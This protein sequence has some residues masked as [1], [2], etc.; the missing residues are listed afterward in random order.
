MAHRWLQGAIKDKSHPV[1][2]AAKENGISALQESRKESHSS[3]QSV[4]SRG[5]LG[6]RLIK[7]RI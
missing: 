3:N 2:R 5:I 4:R 6:V 1:Q 7:K